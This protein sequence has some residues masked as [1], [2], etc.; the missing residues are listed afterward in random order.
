MIKNKILSDHPAKIRLR[1][2]ELAELLNRYDIK[3]KA[4]SDIKTGIRL[5]IKNSVPLDFSS[6][7]V[8]HLII[9]LDDPNLDSEKILLFLLRLKEKN[10]LTLKSLVIEKKSQNAFENFQIKIFELIL[11]IMKESLDL[12]HLYLSFSNFQLNELKQIF[13]AIQNRDLPLSITLSSSALPLPIEETLETIQCLIAKCKFCNLTLGGAGE[14]PSARWRKDINIMANDYCRNLVDEISKQNRENNLLS[15]AI[16]ETVADP[17]YL[18]YLLQPFRNGKN[19]EENIF[20]TLNRISESFFFDVIGFSEKL[21][22]NKGDEI[23]YRLVVRMLL[24]FILNVTQWM[25]SSYDNTQSNGLFEKIFIN[26]LMHVKFKNG[27]PK[28]NKKNS[29]FEEV[30]I[31]NSQEEKFNYYSKLLCLAISFNSEEAT[32]YFVEEI[33][34][35][36]A[37]FISF[38]DYYDDEALH[39]LA[40]ASKNVEIVRLVDDFYISFNRDSFLNETEVNNV[41]TN[42]YFPLEK[43]KEEASDFALQI[44]HKK[45]KESIFLEVMNHVV[46]KNIA[47]GSFHKF[48]QD[49]NKD[50]MTSP[51]LDNEKN[52]Q[53]MTKLIICYEIDDFFITMLYEAINN[54]VEIK[55]NDLLPTLLEYYGHDAIEKILEKKW[56]SPQNLK[57]VLNEENL[58]LLLPYLFSIGLYSDPNSMQG[59]FLSCLI[60]AASFS[61]TLINLV[62]FHKKIRK[63]TLEKGT[64]PTIERHHL[65]LAKRLGNETFFYDYLKEM[66]SLA[67]QDN[68]LLGQASDVNLNKLIY[69]QGKIRLS[70]RSLRL[71]PGLFQAKKEATYPSRLQLYQL[72]RLIL[73]EE[74]GENSQVKEK[75]IDIELLSILS[76]YLTNFKIKH[77]SGYYIHFFVKETAQCVLSETGYQKIMQYGYLHSSASRVE[78]YHQE[79]DTIL[80]QTDKA[81]WD[82]Q[83]VCTGPFEIDIPTYFAKIWIDL[84]QLKL[85]YLDNIIIKLGDYIVRERNPVTTFYL[86]PNICLQIEFKSLAKVEYKFS[87]NRSNQT[88]SIEMNGIDEI[89]H[90]VSGMESCLLYLLSIIN[91]ISNNHIKTELLKEIK[92]RSRDELIDFFNKINREIFRN[93]EIDFHRSLPLSFSVVKSIEF[94]GG[95]QIEINRIKELLTQGKFHSLTKLLKYN[96]KEMDN[97]FFV[98]S[99]LQW[100]PVKYS[101]QIVSLLKEYLP[102]GYL[103]YQLFLDKN[104]GFENKNELQKLVSVTTEQTSLI[105]C[106]CI[107]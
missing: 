35:R 10:L 106:Y 4:M 60:A 2:K 7:F 80:S 19:V 17:I 86:T 102:N 56:L 68:L 65:L 73:T 57:N 63:Y 48:I 49:V 100:T 32:C 91:K 24:R 53:I 40:I 51:F 87:D 105:G 69:I 76:E 72:D 103:A 12:T 94:D 52:H 50:K 54:K 93:M 67:G 75:K 31:W 33:R 20:S 82:D 38:L 83:L 71:Y 11:N 61:G 81:R 22:D 5:E 90:G 96:I 18:S 98:N 97:F 3:N 23:D 59:D 44:M 64:S 29:K 30:V 78:R 43:D 79:G 107:I 14:D 45:Q 62:E 26:F 104:G 28:W 15:K 9:A 34:N 55:W 1:N 21:P 8:D 66:A 89:F 39:V 41:K 6:Q 95:R 77:A 84:T 27:F 74:K 37:E 101:Y 47:I 36:K 58:L 16:S 42:P 85:I 92:S 13:S 46:N 70:D 88:C 99:I 25:L